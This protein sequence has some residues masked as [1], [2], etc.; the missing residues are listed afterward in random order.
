MGL[1]KAQ[2]ESLKR[3][4]KVQGEKIQ[5][6]LRQREDYCLM[7]LEEHIKPRKVLFYTNMPLVREIAGHYVSTLPGNREDN[8]DELILVGA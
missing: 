5:R 1:S 4:N 7:H 3:S 8:L 6:Y 2:I